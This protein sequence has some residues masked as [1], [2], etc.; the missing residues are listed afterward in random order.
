MDPTATPLLTDLYPLNMLQACPEP[1]ETAA[2]SVPAER[3]YGIPVFATMAHSFMQALDAFAHARP[4]NLVILI[5][6]DDAGAAARKVVRLARV[7][8][9]RDGL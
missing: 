5:G 1:G 4:D 9:T 8:K 3:L 7:Q 6:T 2:A